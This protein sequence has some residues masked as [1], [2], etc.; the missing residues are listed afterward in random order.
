MVCLPLARNVIQLGLRVLCLIAMLGAS[1]LSAAEPQWIWAGEGNPQAAPSANAYFRVT[2]QV[3]NPQSGQVEI[4]ADNT[5]SLWI[6]GE[7]IGA[8][9]DWQQIDRF[10]VT[11][12]L[13]KGK[14]VIAVLG[15]NS[16]GP[17]GLVARVTI[18]DSG[19][20]IVT[21]SS[22][23]EWKTAISS[24]PMWWAVDFKD[25]AW[26]AA[27]VF[28]ELG[29][30]APWGAGAKIVPAPTTSTFEKK[31]RPAG[32]FQLLDG[33]RVVFLGD[34]LI[35]RAQASDYIETSLT[36]RY[37]DRK[38][39]FRNLGWSADTVFGES[40][41]GFGSAVDGYQ[42]LKLRVFEQRPT[43]IILGYGGAASSAGPA[44]LNEFSK[45]LEA[46]LNTLE[47]TKA[48]IVILSPLRQ[49]D[50][51]RPLPDPA[52]FN[53]NRKLYSTAMKRVAE[54]RGY[55][56]VDLYEL[57]GDGKKSAAKQAYTDNAIHLTSYGY[58]VLASVLESGL[59]WRA[60][61]WEI[62]IDADEGQHV[63]RGTNLDKIQIEKSKSVRFTATDSVLPP[64]PAPPLSPAG[65]NIPG[66]RRSLKINGL[67]PGNYVLSI[68]GQPVLK[69]SAAEWTKGQV[70]PSGKAPEFAQAEQLR[71]AIRAKNQLFFHRWRPQNETYLFGFRKHEQGNNAKEIPMFDPLIEKVE[72]EIAKLRVPMP[73]A[74]QLVAE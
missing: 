74:Y 60:P 61:H 59:G 65:A 73:H 44:G 47:E 68:D 45:G 70:I 16:D 43:V 67:A 53:E 27:H 69:A 42:Q 57:L 35:E 52:P 7:R 64:P 20:R 50:L 6:N 30:T 54:S 62:E 48:T 71:Q 66:V 58:W 41:A 63:K 25:D 32:P 18:K 21:A 33:D 72:S 17:A 10:D 49:E 15:Q 46:L 26:K 24:Q 28:G 12:R 55:P 9:N 51:G 23:A 29:K 14:N 39:V 4:T 31:A 5:Y 22:G 3:E 56:F 8:G 34:T 2:F 38:I 40:R 36:S 1:T 11:S 37:P 19:N 13:L